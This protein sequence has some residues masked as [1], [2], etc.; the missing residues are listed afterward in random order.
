MFCHKCGNKSL[1]DA[2]FCQKCGEKLIKD[3]AAQQTPAVSVVPVASKPIESPSK[4][5]VEPASPQPKKKMPTKLLFGLAGIAV[6]VAAVFI[7]LNFFGGTKYP[8]EVLFDGR[9]VVQFLDM[10]KADFIREFG[11]PINEQESNGGMINTVTF[12]HVWV[13]FDTYSGKIMCIRLNSYYCTFNGRRLMD[14]SIDTIVNNY[15]KNLHRPV[16]AG[17]I[18]Q[19]SASYSDRYAR[20]HKYNVGGVSYLLDFQFS[21]AGGK[22]TVSWVRI[23]S[24]ELGHDWDYEWNWDG[25][26]QPGNTTGQTAQ[27]GDILIIDL[28]GTL[29]GAPVQGQS[30]EGLELELGNGMF[31]PE[32]E[33]QILGMAAGETKNI[34]VTFPSDYFADELRGQLVVYRVTLH[35]IKARNSGNGGTSNNNTS[36]TSYS[37][38]ELS[39]WL[40]GIRPRYLYD[41]FGTPDD[42]GEYQGGSYYLYGGIMFIT[43]P[44]LDEIVAIEGDPSK[45][46]VNGE[47]LNKTRE[48]LIRILGEP[49]SEGWDDATGA[50]SIY[51]ITSCWI[52]IDMESPYHDAPYLISLF[53]A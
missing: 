1:E 3:E 30:Y 42:V 49:T 32:F 38:D 25:T 21:G 7:V 41:D 45:I 26:N 11:Q 52:R 53:H 19:Q 48:Q 34:E 47:T 50:Y 4:V 28:F 51:F 36:G 33:D 44:A 9:P 35:S 8:D 22:H 24:E 29:N 31:M 27:Y 37:V 16:I 5:T 13:S 18:P 39:G 40:N 23:F 6:V 2:G 17:D 46:T 10:T 43:D 12:E 14:R 15:F 20:W